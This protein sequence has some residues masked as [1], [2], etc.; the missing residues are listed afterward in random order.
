[1]RIRIAAVTALTLVLG[2]AAASVTGIRAL[3]GVV[4]VAGAALCAWWMTRTAGATRT[5]ITL[6][7]VVGLF[8]LA[9][10]L[11]HALGARPA[12]LLVAAAA[13][14]VAYSLAS[15]RAIVPVD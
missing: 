4:L 7:V 10:P 13:G 3:G 6:V 8:V 1:M 11:G 5:V 2:F 14:A 9:H 15:P 12:V